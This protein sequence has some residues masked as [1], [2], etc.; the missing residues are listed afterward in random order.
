MAEDD[1]HN[2]TIKCA[3]SCP[4][5]GASPKE[6]VSKTPKSSVFTLRALEALINIPTIR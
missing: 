6:N 1:E 2:E 3:V 4:E 5:C